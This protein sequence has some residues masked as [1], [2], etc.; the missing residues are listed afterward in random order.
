MQASKLTTLSC[1]RSSRLT[2]YTTQSPPLGIGL[3]IVRIGGSMQDQVRPA[4]S[5]M[6][7]VFFIS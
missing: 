1:S 4:L 5:D 3:N 6:G 2:E 7:D